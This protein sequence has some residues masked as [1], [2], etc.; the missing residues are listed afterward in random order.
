M[1]AGR[2]GAA[3]AAVTLA[4]RAWRLPLPALRS[5]SDRGHASLSS[6]VAPA[7]GARS[8]AE[9]GAALEDTLN[10]SWGSNNRGLG[11]NNYLGKILNAR[12][13]E[14][15]HETPLQHA[16]ALS[17]KTRNRVLLKREDLQPVNSFKIRGAYN[18]I[19]QL[20]H[21]QRAA[22]IVACSAGNH[23]QGVAFS[24]VK[25]GIDA[26]II[27]PTGTPSIKVDACRKMGGNVVLHG[28]TYDE[29]AAEA[30]RLVEAEVSDTTT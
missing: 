4:R 18:K 23:A 1:A 7:A 5:A 29:A 3:P 2:L 28:E 11:H 16:P 10:A 19:A 14:A 13:Y 22:G 27:M 24:A 30:M 21:E 8:S 25:L 17:G 12:V 6:S 26:I 20:S 9:A 15:A